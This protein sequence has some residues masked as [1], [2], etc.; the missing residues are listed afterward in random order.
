MKQLLEAGVH[1]GHQTRRW[2]PRMRNYIFIQRNGIHIIDLQK[3]Q[4]ML[5]R[6]CEFVRQLV[7]D[8]GKILLVGTKKQ[9]Q[10]SVAEEAKRCRM[11]YVNQRWLGGTLTN[12][13]TIQGRIDHL[14][15]LEDQRARGELQRLPKKEALSLDREIERMNRLFAGIKEMT[16][17]PQALFV[18]DPTKERNAVAEARKMGVLLVA[19]VDTDGDPD[20]IDHPIPANDDAIRSIRLITSRIADAV[21][22]G[23]ADRGEA[24][25]AGATE[26]SLSETYVFVPEE[27]PPEA[28]AGEAEV[29]GE[30]VS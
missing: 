27:S 5:Q 6:A 16:S 7:A 10:E 23:L 21:L 17:M 20:L 25:P 30:V 2:N 11:F 18:I 3:T 24:V 15:R 9:A 29:S 4:V 12:F 22:M 28:T 14:V 26:P 19:I 8:G 13:S 1:F